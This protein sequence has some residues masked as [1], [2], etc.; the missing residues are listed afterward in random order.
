MN[1]GRPSGTYISLPRISLDFYDVVLF[2][3]HGILKKL[4][5]AMIMSKRNSKRNASIPTNASMNNVATTSFSGMMTA[6]VY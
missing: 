2:L 5:Q 1:P 6:P 4:H 3:D